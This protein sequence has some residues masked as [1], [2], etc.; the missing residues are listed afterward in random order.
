MRQALRTSFAGW[1]LQEAAEASHSPGNRAAEGVDHD[2]ELVDLVRLQYHHRSEK[3]ND[4]LDD[5]TKKVQE[6]CRA[7]HSEDGEEPDHLKSTSTMEED[8]LK[9]LDQNVVGEDDGDSSLRL[10]SSYAL[11]GVEEQMTMPQPLPR[12]RLTQR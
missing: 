6:A 3:R 1:D 7:S 8:S 5:G 12:G 9:R 4:G 2:R 11:V 10:F